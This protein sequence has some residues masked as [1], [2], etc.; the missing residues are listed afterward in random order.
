MSSFRAAAAGE[1]PPGSVRGTSSLSESRSSADDPKSSKESSENL[2]VLKEK[3]TSI[4]FKKG[5]IK[6]FTAFGLNDNKIIAKELNKFRD[7][8]NAPQIDEGDIADIKQNIKPDKEI[9]KSEN[10]DASTNDDETQT[11]V[12]IRTRFP[13]LGADADAD[14]ALPEVGDSR[15]GSRLGKFKS[16]FR[17]PAAPGDVT[18]GEGGGKRRRSIKRKHRSIRDNTLG[19]KNK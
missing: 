3:K 4:E 12:P 10:L 8:F 2:G 15:V 11:L 13:S 5:M 1:E 6:T 16:M 9:L 7:I 14:A 17:R 19:A 18:S